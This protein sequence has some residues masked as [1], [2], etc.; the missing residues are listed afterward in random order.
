VQ[1]CQRELLKTAFIVYT[2]AMSPQAALEFINASKHTQWML[3]AQYS[4][5]DQGGAY[6]VVV[7]AGTHAVLKINPNPM[8]VREVKR[9]EAATNHLKALGYPVPTYSVIESTD[10]GTYSL[11]S[12]MPGSNVETPGVE[13]INDLIRLI[14]LQKDQMISEVQGQD[15]VWYI[16][17]VV[18]RGESG[19][20]RALMQFS[21][22]TS[23]LVADIETLCLGLDGKVIPKTD[24]VH[25]DMGLDQ[26]LFQGQAV[27]GVLDWDQV[28]Y[29]HRVIDLAALWYSIV[30]SEEPAAAVMKQMLAVSDAE[31]VK[32]CAAYKMLSVVAWNINT[33]GGAVGAAASQARAALRIL[34]KL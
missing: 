5:G 18:F 17:N 6:Q 12:E 25:G 26:V 29:G 23:A 24:L 1:K 7:P 33:V 8:W 11:Q 4:G 13:S 19:N 20:V 28:G 9:A 15:W 16:M 22:E 10:S 30:Q 3:S 27:S 31:S 2:N 14:E 21:A 32:I 34:H